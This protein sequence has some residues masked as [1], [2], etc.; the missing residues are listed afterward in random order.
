[1]IK[2][3]VVE[4][5]QIVALDVA[6]CLQSGGIDVVDTVASGGDAIAAMRRH[7]PDVVLLDIALN[8]DIDGIQVASQIADQWDVPVV[9]LT[10]HGDEQT[11][12]RAQTARPSGYLVKPFKDQDLL[13]SVMTAVYQFDQNRAGNGESSLGSVASPS[14]PDLSGTEEIKK[15]LASVEVLSALSSDEL[16]FI[17]EAAQVYQI[18]SGKTV[19]SRFENEPT[20]FIVAQ[21]CVALVTPPERTPQVILALVTPRDSFGLFSAFDTKYGSADARTIRPSTIVSLPR[22]LLVSLLDRNPQVARK[23]SQE[24]YGRLLEAHSFAG[25]LAAD[26]AERRVGHALLSLIPNFS[27]LSNATKDIPVE[28]SRKELAGYAGLTLETAVRVLRRF[29]NEGLVDLSHRRF[30]KV[31]DA[32]KLEEALSQDSRPASAV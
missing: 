29:S 4:D 27:R 6:R 9:F 22:R 32:K 11:V 1:M 21:G 15:F 19:I 25:S 30:I 17:A 10:A 8:G 16:Q 12:K 13:A 26:R 14:V 31:L 28:V 20:P 23:L 18:E 2:A 3:L 5:E 24:I 7:E